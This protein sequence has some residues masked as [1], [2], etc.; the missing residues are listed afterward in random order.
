MLL[1]ELLPLAELLPLSEPSSVAS[2]AT[3]SSTVESSAMSSPEI[4]LSSGESGAPTDSASVGSP[5]RTSLNP[6]VPMAPPLA[7]SLPTFEAS[8]DV[9]A[10]LEGA[11]ASRS[12]LPPELPAPLRVG[13]P[14]VSPLA[15]PVINLQPIASTMSRS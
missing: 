13:S 1:P 8:S 9:D 3:D 15:Q 11:V 10:S 12:T 4:E 14:V 7:A 2:F 6:S 5:E